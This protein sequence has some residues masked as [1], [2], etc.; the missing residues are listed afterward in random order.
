MAAARLG[1]LVGPSWLVTELDKV[2]LPYHLDAAKQIAGRL[3]LRF[4]DD[5]EVRVRPSSRSANG[6]PPPSAG[7]RSRVALG[8]ELHP[9][10]ARGALGPGGLG[11]A[12]GP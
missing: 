3:A 10:P 7:S 9:L 2:V 6:L 12:A 11:R 1:Y 5:M 4:V 8:G